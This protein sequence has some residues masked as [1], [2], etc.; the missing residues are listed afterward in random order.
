MVTTG[1]VA[2]HILPPVLEV[3]FDDGLRP[4]GGQRKY[5]ADPF[6]GSSIFNSMTRRKFEMRWPRVSISQS[7]SKVGGCADRRRFASRTL[8]RRDTSFRQAA[9]SNCFSAIFLAV[10]STAWRKCMNRIWRDVSSC[11][12]WDGRFQVETTRSTI[13]HPLGPTFP[14]FP[15]L[16]RHSGRFAGA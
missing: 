14:G 8:H 6:I 5:A 1:D 9:P 12:A 13:C 4:R 16:R 15:R 3:A 10:I 2:H 11:W 7:V